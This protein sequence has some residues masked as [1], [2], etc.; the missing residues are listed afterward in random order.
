MSEEHEFRA[1][2]EKFTANNTCIRPDIFLNGGRFCDACPNL[3]YCL[4]QTRRMSRVTEKILVEQGFRGNK[5][6][7]ECQN[8]QS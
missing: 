4:A 7:Q 2:V 5:S 3:K 1:Y 8:E 6:E